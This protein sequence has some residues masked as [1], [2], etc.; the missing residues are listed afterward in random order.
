VGYNL[1]MREIAAELSGIVERAARLLRETSDQE[2]SAPALPG[3]WSRK[4]AIGHLIDSA[5]N[6]HQRFVRAALAGSLVWPGYDQN[7][8]V[9]IQAFQEAPWPMLL[10]VWEAL[11]RLLAHVLEHLPPES[12]AASCRIGEHEPVPLAQLARQYMEH[13]LHHLDQLGIPR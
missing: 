7:G 1:S 12:A 4:Q 11:N 10:D 9:S 2:A 3:G 8:C 5:S 13:M 6:N